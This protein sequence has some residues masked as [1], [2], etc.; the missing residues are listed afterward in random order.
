[1]IEH[2]WIMPSISVALATHNGEK[3]LAEQLESLARQTVRPTEVVVT[4]DASLD[5]TCAIVSD[6]AATAPFS[7]TLHRNDSRLGYRA[8]FLRAAE[9]CKSNLIAFCDQDDVWAPE[10]IAV[11]VQQFHDPDVLLAYHN[12]E[13]V[14]QDGRPLGHLYPAL[15]GVAPLAPLEAN[16]W[17]LVPGFTQMFRRT[18]T[19]YSFLHPASVDAYWPNERLAHDQWYL[20][21]ASVFGCTVQVSQPLVRYRQHGANAFGWR[22]G[23]RLVPGPGYV[24]RNEGFITASRNRSELL[25]RLRDR[26]PAGVQA[27]TRAAIT[28]YDALHK[29]LMARQSVYDSPSLAARV[30]AVRA[31]LRQGAYRSSSSAMGYGWRG[32]ILDVCAGVPLGAKSK[33]L[34]S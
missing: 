12:A 1:M 7:V 9:L 16:P 27:R 19:E 20:F 29:R 23:N 34:F 25:R 10:K 14:D 31:L 33:R 5:R 32:L 4:D 8:N 6:F 30:G 26:P 2:S 15:S 24:L 17:R 3:F 21:L 22:K 28:Y 18:L 11:M 13:I